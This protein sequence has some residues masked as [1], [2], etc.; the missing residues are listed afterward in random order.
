MGQ[1]QRHMIETRR[2][3]PQEAQKNSA[4]CAAAEFRKNDLSLEAS[5]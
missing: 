2:L 3:V 1:K 5:A 4:A